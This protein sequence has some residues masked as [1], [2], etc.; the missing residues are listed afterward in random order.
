MNQKG[1]ELGNSI[2][3]ANKWTTEAISFLTAEEIPTEGW[4]N[5]SK[6]RRT[7]LVK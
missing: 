5:D 2:H 3:S 7:T 6:L 4:E 1:N